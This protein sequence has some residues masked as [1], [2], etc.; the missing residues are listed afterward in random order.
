MAICVIGIAGHIGSGKSE[1]MNY[2]QQHKSELERFVDQKVIEKDRVRFLPEY[3]DTVGL[4]LF[5]RDPHTYADDFEE[6]LLHSRKIRHCNAKI[7][8][9][10]VIVERTLLEGFHIFC[11]NS[12]DSGFLSAAGYAD[13]ERF[14]KKSVAKLKAAEQQSWNESLLVYHRIK[15]QDLGVLAERQLKRKREGEEGISQDYNLAIQ[16]GYNQFFDAANLSQNYGRW[17]LQAPQ[18]L[19]IDASVDFNKDSNYHRRILDGIIG[20]A[21]AGLNGRRK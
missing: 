4:D 17:G 11:Q 10:I 18:V 14:V 8:P 21:E 19:E 12:R 5:Y 16:A 2:L 1:T 3:V 9:G 15:D 20:A 7:S 6:S 13:C